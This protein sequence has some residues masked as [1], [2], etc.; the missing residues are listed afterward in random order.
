MDLCSNLDL[1]L[2]TMEIEILGGFGWLNQGDC[3]FKIES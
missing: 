1:G 2:Q 3:N